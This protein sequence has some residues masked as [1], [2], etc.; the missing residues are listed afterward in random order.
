M[1]GSSSSPPGCTGVVGSRKVLDILGGALIA[2]YRV[3]WDDGT[4][5]IYCPGP[6]A[7][8]HAP[9][10]PPRVKDPPDRH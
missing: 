2:I 3:R 6:D 9:A 7:R 5:S 10:S 8:V 4:E 1:I